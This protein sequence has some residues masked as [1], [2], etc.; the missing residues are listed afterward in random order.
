MAKGHYTNTKAYSC[1]TTG[2][3]EVAG[4]GQLGY[5]AGPGKVAMKTKI[6]SKDLGV[7]TSQA[8]GPKGMKTY[9]KGE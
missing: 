8:K 5:A 7:S 3:G 6:D 4:A 2:P 1:M 9:A